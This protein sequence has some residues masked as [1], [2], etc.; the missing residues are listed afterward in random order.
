[1]VIYFKMQGLNEFFKCKV[2][3]R[4]SNRG[5]WV[6]DITD[7]EE[8]S[9]Y[10]YYKQDIDKRWIIDPFIIRNDIIHE[11]GNDMFF[12]KFL[13]ILDKQNQT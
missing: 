3:F 9:K 12:K 4:K 2:W 10:C 8:I 6:A 5:H 13:K 11:I 1:M 7:K